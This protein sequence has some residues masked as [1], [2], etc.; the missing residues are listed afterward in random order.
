[1]A[2]TFTHAQR[3]ERED[4]VRAALDKGVGL[5]GLAEMFDVSKQA[6]WQFCDVRGWLDKARANDQTAREIAREAKPAGALPAPPKVPR[7]PVDPVTAAKHK[8]ARAEAKLRRKADAA[9]AKAATEARR[10]AEAAQRAD[11]DLARLKA[12]AH[13]KKRE[14]MRE[15]KRQDRELTKKIVKSGLDAQPELP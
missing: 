14:Y 9:L 1:M 15:K 8:T 6:M 3:V 2:T 4:A 13:A 12:E 11:V 5:I 10:A 7:A